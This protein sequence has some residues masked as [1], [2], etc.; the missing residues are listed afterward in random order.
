MNYRLVVYNP[1]TL[2][3]VGVFKDRKGVV[4]FDLG[5]ANALKRFLEDNKSV[6]CFLYL[7]ER[8]EDEASIPTVQ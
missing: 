2:E 1:F 6:G 8:L 4:V 5:K 3:A 7:V